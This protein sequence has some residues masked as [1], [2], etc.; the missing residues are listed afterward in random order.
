MVPALQPALSAGPAR[1]GCCRLLRDGRGHGA[2]KLQL[3]HRMEAGAAPHVVAGG[4][5]PPWRRQ[6]LAD[7][8]G[9]PVAECPQGW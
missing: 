3:R 2:E 1:F 8:T 9:S 5:E 6:Q 7:L 4:P